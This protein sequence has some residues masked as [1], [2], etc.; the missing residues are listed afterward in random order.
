MSTKKSMSDARWET[1]IEACRDSNAFVCNLETTVGQGGFPKDKRFVFRA[2]EE[3]LQPLVSFSH[4]T[5]T[6]ANNHS[7]D[8]GPLGLLA[9]IAILKNR[10][11]AFCGGGK[12]TE[13]A[14]EGTKINYRKEN[15]SI[16][17]F[18]FDED[19]SS[20][21]DTTGACIAPLEMDKMIERVSAYAST[22]ITTIVMLHWGNEYD[23]QFSGYQQ[24]I[25][26]KLVKAGADLV[27]GSGPH[28]LQGFEV[29]QDSLICYSVGNLIFDDLSSKETA[30][31]VLVRMSLIPSGNHINKKF[32]IA[33]LRTKDIFA[34][35]CRP[36][37]EDAQ[38][39]IKNLSKRSPDPNILS[40]REKINEQGLMWFRIKM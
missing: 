32:E 18:G 34:G 23:T 39:I 13:E 21:S 37:P 31:S 40:A 14:T 6:L 17:S 10:G 22:S 38:N 35:P 19:I 7:M 3:A 20:Y 27:I 28:V 26:Y 12:T 2:P 4:P 36:S 9:T 11:I 8:Y 25:A 16:L 1:L 5:L 15:I 24:N 33:P 30:S 29:Y